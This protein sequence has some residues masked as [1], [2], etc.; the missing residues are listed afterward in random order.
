MRG[1]H[2]DLLRSVSRSF[3]LSLR[4]LPAPMRDPVSL[5]YLL[6]RFSDTVADAPAIAEADRI[7]ALDRFAAAV[8]GRAGGTPIVSADWVASLVRPGERDLAARI[9]LLLDRLHA[10]SASER[11]L[12]REVLETI[13]RGQRWDLLAFHDDPVP[14]V[15]AEDLLLYTHRVAG[16]VGEFWTKIA[17]TQLGS[18]FADP[19]Q[20]PAMLGS[21]RKL[22][23]AL[24]LVNILRDLHEDFPRG[25]C[26][27]PADELR[28]AGWSGRGMPSAAAVAPV[29]RHWI[30]R[31]R[32]LL[33]EAESYTRLV[34]DPRI[35]FSTRLPMLLAAGTLR[36]LEEAGPERVLRER[37]KV[38]RATVSLCA[39]RALLF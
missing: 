21:G 13:L 10:L 33:D 25:R 35:R 31:C 9:D 5:A 7:A 14:C 20:I 15:N 19:D 4:F 12:V 28:A 16:C 1:S 38:G 29:F 27:L 30:D 2:D 11:E 23:Q 37:V 32:E 34:R 36:L 17:A 24:Q 6:A 22:G 18:R 8:S 39:L 26:Y 3:Y